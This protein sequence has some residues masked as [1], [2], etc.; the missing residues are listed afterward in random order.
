MQVE[1][2]GVRN[3]S[4]LIT[5]YRPFVKYALLLLDVLWVDLISDELVSFNCSSFG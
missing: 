5:I 4:C 3:H 1:G 2:H